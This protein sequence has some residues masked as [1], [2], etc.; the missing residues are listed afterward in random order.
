MSFARPDPRGTCGGQPRT[1]RDDS[2]PAGDRLATRCAGTSR[3]RS[4]R[5]GP[6]ALDPLVLDDPVVRVAD[7]Q[8]TSLSTGHGQI[9]DSAGVVE[10]FAQDPTA[11]IWQENLPAPTRVALNVDRRRR[12]RPRRRRGAH[13]RNAPTGLGER[14]SHELDDLI[15]T[16]PNHAN[17]VRTLHAGSAENPDVALACP[18]YP[19]R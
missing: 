6:V 14:S 11:P 3:S 4:G 12:S 15:R 19:Q 5:L 18:T 10:R 8:L 2:G 16:T 7:D 1:G 17:R 9:R 13:A